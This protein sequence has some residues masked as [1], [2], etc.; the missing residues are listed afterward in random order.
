LLPI[1]RYW[2]HHCIWIW[3]RRT[4]HYSNCIIHL[5][6][7][8]C[9]ENWKSQSFVAGSLLIVSVTSNLHF[10]SST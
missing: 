3:S 8:F 9:F 4:S 6:D 5:S 7:W 2:N 1:Q 10:G